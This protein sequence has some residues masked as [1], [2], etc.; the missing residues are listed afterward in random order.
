MCVGGEGGGVLWL[1]VLMCVVFGRGEG[2]DW[3]LCVSDVRLYTCKCTCIYMGGGGVYLIYLFC[4]FVL[5]L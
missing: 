1:N 4:V 3:V 2:G 5:I